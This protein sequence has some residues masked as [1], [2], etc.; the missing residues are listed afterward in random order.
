MAKW[1]ILYCSFVYVFFE[2]SR[3][4]LFDIFKRVISF[5]TVTCNAIIK[6]NWTN[7]PIMSKNKIF[8]NGSKPDDSFKTKPMYWQKNRRRQR[9][10]WQL[11]KWCKRWTIHD[12]PH[13][14]YL[15]QVSKTHSTK[16]RHKVSISISASPAL[17]IL[18][19]GRRDR[20]SNV[21]SWS[22]P[23]KKYKIY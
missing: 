5:I 3:A 7:L 14:H 2:R 21:D 20:L 17:V 18:R 10:W 1:N 13:E 15:H 9:H 4:L 8:L 12:N 23:K 16:S 22:P 6:K 19:P 11:L